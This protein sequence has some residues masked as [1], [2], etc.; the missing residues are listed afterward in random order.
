MVICLQ[1]FLSSLNDSLKTIFWAPWPGKPFLGPGVGTEML[2]NG[3]IISTLHVATA[4][5]H[6]VPCSATRRHV[7]C[8]APGRGSLAS[9]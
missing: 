5:G 8:T 9:L 1:M 4:A 7:I 2:N 3:P 6:H